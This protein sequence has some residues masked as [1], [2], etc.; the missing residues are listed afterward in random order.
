MFYTEKIMSKKLS[1]GEL[2]ERGDLTDEDMNLL[3]KLEVSNLNNTVK[4]SFADS[5]IRNLID[6]EISIYMST[7]A[8]EKKKSLIYDKY[9]A[10]MQTTWLLSLVEKELELKWDNKKYQDILIY[11]I[12]EWKKTYDEM[13]VI[14]GIIKWNI[15]INP[16]L[17]FEGYKNNN[18]SREMESFCSIPGVKFADAFE[19]FN[20]MNALKGKDKNT[21]EV[22]RLI[23]DIDD[24]TKEEAKEIWKKLE[25]SS[26]IW[27]YNIEALDIILELDWVDI[28]FLKQNLDQILTMHDYQVRVLTVFSKLDWVDIT[29]VLTIQKK[30]LLIK[31]EN[32]LILEG[33]CLGKNIT[34]KQV[35]EDLDIIASWNIDVDAFLY[36]FPMMSFYQ[37]RENNDGVVLSDFKRILD[38][39]DEKVFS[40]SFIFELFVTKFSC[41][42]SQQLM[43]ILDRLLDKTPEEIDNIREMLNDVDDEVWR[44]F[45]DTLI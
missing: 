15:D 26:V 37:W 40:L 5:E 23:C 9:M 12:S 21:L 4:D 11:N 28:S 17:L 34:K 29:D 8:D 41:N 32:A 2:E 10:L 36:K 22:F 38:I 44:F 33:Y 14:V 39:E 3:S 24:I 1:I 35:L 30:V 42:D 19:Q 6:K 25:D 31:K 18:I 27:E 16:S 45:V 43:R 13:Q 7:T 20:L